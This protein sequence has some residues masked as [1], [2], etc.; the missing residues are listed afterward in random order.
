[1]WYVDSKHVTDSTTQFE[2]MVTRL[3]CNDGTTGK[4][5]PPHIE[6]N[7]AEIV[8]TFEVEQHDGFHDC[9]SNDVVSYKANL[10]EPLNGRRLVDGGCRDGNAA[11]MGDCVQP[12][13]W[14]PG[15]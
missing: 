10:S 4:I 1:M 13:R 7:E 3:G 12:T 8:V 2:A 14:A 9:P 6:Y 5:F 15:Q 11:P